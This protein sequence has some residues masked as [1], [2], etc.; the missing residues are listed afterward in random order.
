MAHHWLPS[1]CL[2]RAAAGTV[3]SLLMQTRDDSQQCGGKEG[4]RNW[5]LLHY[6]GQA[7]WLVPG[8]TPAAHTVWLDDA[9]SWFLPA[10]REK[11][12]KPLILQF[13]VSPAINQGGVQPSNKLVMSWDFTQRNGPSVESQRKQKA[14]C[15]HTWPCHWQGVGL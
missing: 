8:P 1:Y 5:S 4:F 14:L 2:K 15:S 10:Q 12:V 6:L 13:R 7:G 9:P 11:W 3:G